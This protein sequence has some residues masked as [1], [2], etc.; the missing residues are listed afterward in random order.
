MN[1]E[2]EIY[3]D[4]AGDERR[5]LLRDSQCNLEAFEKIMKCITYENFINIDY[6]EEG[7]LAIVYSAKWRSGYITEFDK[8]KAQFSHDNFL[9]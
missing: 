8:F 3:D 1:D 2:S 4:E 6:F 9:Q 5:H 7:G